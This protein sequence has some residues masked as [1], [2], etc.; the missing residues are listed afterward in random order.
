M[1]QADKPQKTYEVLMC[2]ACGELDCLVGS[3]ARY[4]TECRTVEDYKTVFVNENNEVV[5]EE[6][7]AEND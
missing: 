4:C 3:D 7:N 2:N 1:N 6:D 5:N